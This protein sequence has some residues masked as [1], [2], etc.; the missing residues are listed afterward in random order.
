[1]YVHAHKIG[2][3]SHQGPPH[4]HSTLTAPHDVSQGNRTRATM[5]ALPTPL[6]HPR[7]YG[8]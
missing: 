6:H 7:P 3:Q 4:I 5:K 8:W 2:Q 1:M